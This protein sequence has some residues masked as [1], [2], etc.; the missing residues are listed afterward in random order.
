[1]ACLCNLAGTDPTGLSRRVAEL[2]LGAFMTPAEALV[3]EGGSAGTP[4]DD[5]P[6]V[7]LSNA[8]LMRWVG[9]YRDSASGRL[10]R[11]ETA[12]GRL[13]LQMPGTRL[14][15]YPLRAL[16]EIRFRAADATPPIEFRFEGSAGARRITGRQNDNRLTFLE[17]EEVTP[18]QARAYA[19][20]YHSDE[21][22]VD[23]VI[24]VDGADLVL[25]I[26][27]REPEPLVPTVERTFRFDS[28]VDVVFE[29]FDGRPAAFT[30][31]AGRVRGIRFV[32]VEDAPRPGR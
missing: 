9:A 3:A 23:Y 2:F 6:A 24:E 28:S 1:V 4:R 18:D 30:V 12:D 7:A 14:G 5:E 11:V 17:I 26:A 10:A 16:S 19:G 13:V 8:Q 32:R 21:L 29:P 20:R 15:T 27:R 31:N 25:R 22:D